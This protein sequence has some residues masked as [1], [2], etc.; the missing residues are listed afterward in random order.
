GAGTPGRARQPRR[1]RRPARLAVV[2][3]WCGPAA[4]VGALSLAIRSSARPAALAALSGPAP[5][6][7]VPVAEPAVPR[8]MG[9]GRGRRSEPAGHGR[10]RW[11]DADL[12]FPSP[13]PW[14]PAQPR[15]DGPRAEQGPPA[16]R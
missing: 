1:P 7:T 12:A 2:G 6:A 9:T 3:C 11:P 10:E 15:W 16:R 14:R 5:G 13:R 4:A 8:V